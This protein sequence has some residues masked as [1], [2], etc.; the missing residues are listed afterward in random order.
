[1]VFHWDNTP[2]HTAIIVQDWLT[3]HSIQA[4]RHPPYLPDLALADFFLFWPMKDELAGITLDHSTLKRSG[5]G[6]RETSP[7]RSSPPA[8]GSGM[9]ATKIVLKWVVAMLRNHKKVF[10]SIT[11]VD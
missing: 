6:P 3:A 10:L 11:V 2:V 1:M 5:K 9:S 4:L 7:L 8:S